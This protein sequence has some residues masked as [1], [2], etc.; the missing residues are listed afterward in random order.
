MGLVITLNYFV[1]LVGTKWAKRILKL[2]TNHHC[3]G[4][5]VNSEKKRM[6]FFFSTFEN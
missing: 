5:V 2:N 3:A 1:N 4:K 6:W